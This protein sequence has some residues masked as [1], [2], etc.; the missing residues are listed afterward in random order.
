MNPSSQHQTKPS[1]F[2]QATGEITLIG[3][4]DSFRRVP[5]SAPTSQTLSGPVI[6]TVD[7]RFAMISWPRSA[8]LKPSITSAT[9]ASW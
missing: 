6:S 9:A 1:M 2:E 3:R 4:S 7:N 5:I 8:A